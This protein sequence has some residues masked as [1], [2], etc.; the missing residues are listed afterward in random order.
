MRNVFQN[1]EDW[2]GV[3][4]V[5]TR[6]SFACWFA[7]GNLKLMI[8]KKS[9]ISGM[10][11]NELAHFRTY[12]DLRWM[13]PLILFKNFTIWSITKHFAWNFIFYLCI[14]LL[15]VIKKIIGGCLVDI[16]WEFR[17]KGF[18]ADEIKRNAIWNCGQIY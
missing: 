14:K 5:K 1:N 15:T 4:W 6:D 16:F 12:Y 7:V 3:R 2:L 17:F 11:I 8:I 13:V 18:T 10:I 9:I